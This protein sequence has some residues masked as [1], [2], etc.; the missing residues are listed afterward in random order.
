MELDFTSDVVE[1]LLLKKA[2]TDKNWLDILANVYDKRWFRTKHVGT[3]LGLILKFYGKYG[4]I[5]NAT[6]VSALAKKYAENHPTDDEFSVA[7]ANSLVSESISL[8]LGLDDDVV[9]NNLR[10]FIRKNALTASLMD[11]IDLLSMADSEKDADR[12][13]KIVDK[14][15]ENFDRVQRITFNDSDLGLDYFDKSQMDAHWD[16]LKNPDVKIATKWDSVDQYTNGGFLKDGRMI[17]L[18]MA[19]AGLG[20]SVFMSNL[21]VNFLRQNL[22][23]VVISLEMS[24]DVYAQRFDA[25]ISSKNINRLAENEQVARERIMAFYRQHEGANLV[26]KEYP[27]RSVN[28]KTIDAYLEKLK[29]SGKKIDVIVIDY[30]NLV[31]PNKVSDSMFKD[32]LS[33]SEELRALS[34][35]YNAPVISACQCNSE[36]MNSEEIDMQNISESRGI[37]HTVDFLAALYQTQEQRERG[38]LGFKIIKNRLGGMIGKRSTFKMDPETLVVS[39]VTFSGDIDVVDNGDSELAKLTAALPDVTNDISSI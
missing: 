11:N 8:N 21:A 4:K 10:E 6:L 32:G 26:I 17:A 7:E 29:A 27:P 9:R 20:K 12:Y 28:T 3:V 37:V 31:L 33:V 39:D 1:K 22:S 18:F 14:C 16:F 24:Q 35:K 2:L 15:L 13:Q 19:Q 38:K 5:P 36:G 23:V 25:H 34:Y 30:L